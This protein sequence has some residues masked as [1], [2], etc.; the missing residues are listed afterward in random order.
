MIQTNIVCL[1][2]DRMAPWTALPRVSLYFDTLQQF[3]A[4]CETCVIV[5]GIFHEK[6]SFISVH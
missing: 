3:S 6:Y 4:G 1:F 5:S 2:A